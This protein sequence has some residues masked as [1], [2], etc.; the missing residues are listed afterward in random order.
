[1]EIVFGD[2][3]LGVLKESDEYI[4]AYNTGGLESLKTE[5]HEHLYRTPS[6]AFWRAS[7]DNDRGSG[8]SKASSIWMGA[9]LFYNVE[10]FSVTAD[11]T[12]LRWDDLIPPQNNSLLDSPLRKAD[13][14]SIR[15]L[16][17]T[18]TSPQAE[19][20]VT[21]SISSDIEGLSVDYV[22]RGSEGLPSFPLCGMRFILPYRITSFAWDG[23][24]GETYPDRLYGAKEGHFEMEGIERCPYAKTQ[25]YGMH[26]HTSSLEIRAEDRNLRLVSCTD[27]GFSFSLLP[28]SAQEMEMAYHPADLP[29]YR[30]TYLTVAAA[31]R[32]VG[33]IDSWMSP[34]ASRFVLD[35]SAEY[36]TSFRI[37]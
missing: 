16:Y 23:L 29:A 9:D 17:S 18:V 24:S 5:G 1:M 35:A 30:R 4:F 33:G 2:L 11:G 7:T 14:I 8:F 13:D 27:E 25:D 28:A 32:G 31:V 19:V 15:F 26:M 37:I 6:L 3:S 12:L 10:N 22:Y 34:P 36:R 20:E 21:Y